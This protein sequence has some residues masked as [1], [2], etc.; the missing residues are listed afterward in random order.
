LLWII[1]LDALVVAH[2]KETFVRRILALMGI[3]TFALPTDRSGAQ[4]KYVI[5]D[6]ADD[7]YTLRNIIAHGNEIPLAYREEQRFEFTDTKAY[8]SEPVELAETRISIGVRHIFVG[9]S[10]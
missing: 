7:L 3:D 6:V 4:P 8:G 2:D 9:S 10:A 1:A 5:G